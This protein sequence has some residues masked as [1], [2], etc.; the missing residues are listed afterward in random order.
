VKGPVTDQTGKRKSILG[1]VLFALFM[2]LSV[3]VLISLFLDQQA[4]FEALGSVRWHVLV[5]PFLCYAAIYCVDYLRL[6]VVLAQFGLKIGLLA[7]LANGILTVFFSNLTPMAGGG[8]PYQ[9]FHLM[10][11]G[12]DSRKAMNVVLSRYVEYMLSSVLIVL[13]SLPRLA[14][15]ARGL[16]A[17][18]MLLYSGLSVTAGFAILFLLALVRPDWLGRAAF[19]MQGRA[20][21][22]LVGRL[23][24]HPQ[25]GRRVLVWTRLFRREVVFLWTR[26][27]PSMLLDSL[28]GLVNLVLQALSLQ[29][30]L[31]FFT[32]APVLFADVFFTFV[33]VNMVVYYVPTPGA[34]GSIEGAYSLVFS[35][36]VGSLEKG[37][38]VILIWRLATYYLHLLLGFMVYWFSSGNRGERERNARQA[39]L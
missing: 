35:G 36:F 5:A 2:G 15:I 23:A 27:L 24:H 12:I 39:G 21:G 33:M 20:L 29:T 28:L 25:W 16:G 26:R 3:N 7:G 32:P 10:R 18:L 22:R 8:Q 31:G 37:L 9:V 6:R 34:S 1:A 17:G 13:L 38:S 30:V 4:L 14:E 19:W 11:A